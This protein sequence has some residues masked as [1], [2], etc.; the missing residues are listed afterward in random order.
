M[1]NKWVKISLAIN[2]VLIIAVVF[3]FVKMPSE[4]SKSSDSK[5]EKKEQKKKQRMDGA[6]VQIAYI[7]NDSLVKNYKYVK[8]IQRKLEEETKTLEN[9]LKTKYTEYQNW[10]K[11]LQDKL[12]TMLRS[13]IEDAQAKALKK[14]QELQQFEQSL[15]M[16]LMQMENELLTKHVEKVQ[17][18]LQ[19]YAQEEGYDYVFG[20]QLGGNLLY[21]DEIHDITEEVIDLLN[22]EYEEDKLSD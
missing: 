20:Y 3:L 16:Q 7:N 12:P 6:P 2:A 11:K 13:E 19:S 15:Q 14:Q 17:K 4:V 18:F 9:T 8:D 1:E 21:G 22:K 5:K 10:E